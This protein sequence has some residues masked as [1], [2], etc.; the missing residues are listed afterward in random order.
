MPQGSARRSTVAKVAPVV[1]RL[2][3]ATKTRAWM[4]TG[5]GSDIPGSCAVP[6]R[7]GDGGSHRRNCLAVTRRPEARSG[8]RGEPCGR[9]RAHAHALDRAP[10]ARGRCS[11][12]IYPR[13]RQTCGGTGRAMVV[14][15]RRAWRTGMERSNGKIGWDRV[16]CMNSLGPERVRQ[17]RGGSPS[18]PRAGLLSWRT[19]SRRVERPEISKTDGS[20]GG[21]SRCREYSKVNRTNARSAGEVEHDTRGCVPR[22]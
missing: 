21:D 18:D 8:L 17:I 9:L 11:S 1:F 2:A 22:T 20:A 6:R 16:D 3:T 19:Q 12:A 5:S 10:D 14:I 15:G 7:S 13:G 4:R